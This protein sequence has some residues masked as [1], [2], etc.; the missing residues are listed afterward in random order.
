M[1]MKMKWKN[2]QPVEERKTVRG[3]KIKVKEENLPERCCGNCR[4]YVFDKADKKPVCTKNPEQKAGYT[5][6][7]GEWADENDE[8]VQ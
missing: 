7:C 4:Y 6:L 8:T 1:E 3:A 5:D 2:G